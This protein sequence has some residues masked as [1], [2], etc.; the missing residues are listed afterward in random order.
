MIHQTSNAIILKISDSG[1]KSGVELLEKL[2]GIRWKEEMMRGKSGEG[3]GEGENGEEHG[4]DSSIT[5]R[6]LRPVN[7][8][9]LSE[10][11]KNQ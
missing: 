1:V 10:N 6:F 3:E 4:Q 11:Y 8:I 5:D 2:P 9:T 7:K